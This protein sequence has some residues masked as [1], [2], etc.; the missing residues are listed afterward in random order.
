M[1]GLKPWYSSETLLHHIQNLTIPL[2]LCPYLP[3]TSFFLDVAILEI[4]QTHI[5]VWRCFC[6]RQ[7][8]TIYGVQ[9][10]LSASD[11]KLCHMQMAVSGAI[12]PQ[13]LSVA[14]SGVHYRFLLRALT[15]T[16]RSGSGLRSSCGW[17]DVGSLQ[18]LLPLWAGKR[19]AAEEGPLS[20]RWL[21]TWGARSCWQSYTQ[22]LLF[23][24]FFRCFFY[25]PIHL[26]LLPSCLSAGKFTW[27]GD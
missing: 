19:A 12:H 18:K 14:A 11:C 22:P 27:S 4:F 15:A 6:G 26:S 8:R 7:Q 17:L 5:L 25:Q 24:F 16:T 3:F 9:A 13:L 20:E 2:L 23:W 10:S 21:L 1:S